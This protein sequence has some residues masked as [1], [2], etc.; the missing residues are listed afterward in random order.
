VANLVGVFVISN[1][2]NIV[3]SSLF[4]I[5]FGEYAAWMVLPALVSILVSFVALALVF[6][7]AIP[8]RYHQERIQPPS[9]D[10]IFRR[11]SIVILLVTLAALLLQQVIGVPIWIVA[12]TGAAALMILSTRCRQQTPRQI[13]AG[14]GWDVLV[15]VFGIFIVA[16][17]LR[18]AGLTHAI[19]SLLLF[20]GRE[21]VMLLSVATA[22]VAAISSSIMNNHPTVDMMSWVI[23]DLALPASE[24]RHLALS[25]LVGGDLGPKMLPIGSLA[26]LL[27]FRILRA[28]GVDIPFSLY[29]VIGIPLTI[30]AV[31]LSVLVLN[32]EYALTQWL[33]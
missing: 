33:L 26:A 2:I 30:A 23:R 6:R 13:L 7:R 19:G 10:A 3:I 28:K 25:A 9:G 15:F 32:A 17:G 1:P 29:I 21:S 4:D 24:T 5:E 16:M 20:L 31:A 22:F 11:L 14:V 18:N 27:W 12:S 8:A